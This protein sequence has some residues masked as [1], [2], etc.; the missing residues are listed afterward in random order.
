MSDLIY[1]DNAATTWPKPERVHRFMSD[2]YREFGVNPG[3]SG[4]DKA[5]ET[6]EMIHKCRSKLMKLF[7]GE[8]PDRLVFA[9]NATDGLNQAIQGV[10]LRGGHVISSNLEHN[11]VLR[12]LW[13]LT[14]NGNIDVTYLP[15]DGDG[16]I[17]PDE[18]RK[19]IKPNTRL[20]VLNHGSNVIGTLQPVGEFG[21][22]CREKGITFVV[23][24]S[25]TAGVVPI[26]MK[27]MCID[28]VCF[29]GHK[30]LFGPTGIGGI[31]VGPDVDIPCTRWGGTGVKSAQRKHLDE[32]PYHLEA[33]T[34]NILGIA[35]LLAGQE[36]I[37]SRGG[38]EA[39]CQHEM[40]LLE[41]LWSG[42]RE[43]E[44]VKMYCADT[45]DGHIPVLSMNIEG[46]AAADTGTMLDV[47]HDIATRTGL[48]CAPAVHEQLG[49]DLIKGTVRFSVGAFNTIEQID[50]AIE[51]VKDIASTAEVWR[52]RR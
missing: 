21:Q 22:I 44:G 25:Q 16:F 46:L 50:T 26:D 5:L 15:F 9:Y 30:S 6:E 31:C 39:I 10:M 11:S 41:R 24:A 23:D 18:V 33:G 38:I 52:N 14:Q 19:A 47:D 4:Y 37:E 48:H 7:G 51:A 2:F 1:L 35:G 12:P 13:H 42:F 36:F 43:I 45:L 17:H 40:E 34:V 28:M 29:T 3:R 8:N 49:T 27:S 32:Y 20:V